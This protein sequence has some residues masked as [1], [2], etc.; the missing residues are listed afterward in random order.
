MALRPRLLKTVRLAHLYLGVFVAPAVLFFAFTGAVQ[1]FSLHETTPGSSYRPPHIFE[2]LAQI[3]KKQTPVLPPR[4]PQPGPQAAGPRSDHRNPADASRPAT[5]SPAP[6]GAPQAPSQP[7][8]KH[9]PL[10]LK[11]FFLAVALSLCLSTFSGI[12]MAYSYARN[13]PAITTLLVLGA[14]IPLLMIFL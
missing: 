4:R 13:K 10:P 2:V 3:H 5:P 12:T 1:T 6:T 14:V 11:I 8:P 7:A 9:N